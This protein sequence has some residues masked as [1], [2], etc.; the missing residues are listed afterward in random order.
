MHNDNRANLIAKAKRKVQ[1]QMDRGLD[2]GTTEE[3]VNSDC[4]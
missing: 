1:L 4:V 3:C 2:E